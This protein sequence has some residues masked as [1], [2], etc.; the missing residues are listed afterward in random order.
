MLLNEVL[1]KARNDA[2][3]VHLFTAE[4]GYESLVRIYPEAILECPVVQQIG[5]LALH[6]LPEDA[7]SLLYQMLE[8]SP[9]QRIS[10]TAALA[11][12]Y[13]GLYSTP[14]DEPIAAKAPSDD[15]PVDYERCV[16]T[17]VY[18]RDNFP[19]EPIDWIEHRNND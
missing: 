8:L 15:F 3:L 14:W 18:M 11:H 16:P 19:N 9:D 13:V 12:P 6:N 1:F 5:H 7:A 10:A 17:M 2:H 4:F